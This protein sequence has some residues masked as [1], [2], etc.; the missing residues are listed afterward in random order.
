MR[1]VVRRRQV[2]AD[3]R[4]AIR[5]KIAVEVERILHDGTPYAEISVE[6]ICRATGISRATFYQYF[7]DKADLLSQLA[8]DTLHSLG[9]SALFWWHLPAGSDVA[10]LRQSFDQAFKVYQEHRGVLRSLTQA[11]AYDDAIAR[12]LRDILDWGIADTR[13]HI[14][15]GIAQGFVRPEVDAEPTAQWLCWMFERGLYEVAGQPDD[16]DLQDMLTAV[17]D[18]VWNVLYRDAA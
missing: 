18:V 9:E 4:K 2:R 7:R 15:E 5:D 1:T 11:A 3:R 8:E 12:R 13:R 16:Q 6:R 10:T 14:E 17:T